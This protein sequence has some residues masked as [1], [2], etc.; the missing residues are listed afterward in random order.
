MPRQQK[1]TVLVI[2]KDGTETKVFLNSFRDSYSGE[3]IQL[4]NGQTVPF[5]KIRSIDFLETHDY[6]QE[7]SVTLTDGRVLEGAIMSGEQ[8]TGDTDIGPFS[9]SVKSLKRILFE[10]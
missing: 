5:D 4:K 8:M 6:G 7:V 9:I 10:H 2:G 3:A 1:P